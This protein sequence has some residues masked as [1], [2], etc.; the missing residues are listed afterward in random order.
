[1]QSESNNKDQKEFE[2]K[3]KENKKNKSDKTLIKSDEIK[4]NNGNNTIEQYF[5][6][7]NKNKNERE[8]KIPLGNEDN[9]VTE[10][11]E[12]L[13]SKFSILYCLTVII[14]I[15]LLF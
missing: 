12:K 14:K 4:N 8:P 15:L 10:N 1:M 2:I 11:N 7:K 5:K 13:T 3:K 9:K 6:N